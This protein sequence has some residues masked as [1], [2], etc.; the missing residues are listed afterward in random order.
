LIA[1]FTELAARA[2]HKTGV[3]MF[4]RISKGRY[5]PE[6]HAAVQARLEASSRS[7]IPAISAMAGCLSYYVGSDEASSTMINVSVW[8]THEHAQAM[9]LLPEMASLAKEF[10]ALGVE[11]ERPIINYSVLWQLP[12]R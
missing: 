1:D 4:V 10:I 3:L 5:S 8:D 11:F 7:L 6:L 2:A 9:S 12:Q